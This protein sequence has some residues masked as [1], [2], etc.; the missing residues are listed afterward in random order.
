MKNRFCHHRPNPKHQIVTLLT[1]TNLYFT[2]NPEQ[3][4]MI[5][6]GAWRAFVDDRRHQAYDEHMADLN[7]TYYAQCY[8]RTYADSDDEY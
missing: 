4:A 5:I 1:T 2:M 8:T 3:A 6:Q 7:A